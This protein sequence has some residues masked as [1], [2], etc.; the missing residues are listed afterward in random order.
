MLETIVTFIYE[1]FQHHKAHL[2]FIA[3][4]MV[5]GLFSQMILPG[6][7]F[8][9][10]ATLAIGI[11]G[12]YIGDMFLGDYVTEYV[13]FTKNATIHKIIGGV[14]GAMALSFIINLIRGGKDKDKTAYRN[15]T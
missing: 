4:G 2:I 7:G 1:T 12:C 11:A 13:T 15:N 8:G 9:L 14:V 5:V 6:R 3:I 10:L